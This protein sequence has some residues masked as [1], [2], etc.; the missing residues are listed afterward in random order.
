MHRNVFACVVI[1]LFP[2]L[3]L[4]ACDLIATVNP[5]LVDQATEEIINPTETILYGN[6]SGDLY[7][8]IEDGFTSPIS[9]QWISH[10][11][12]VL[13]LSVDKGFKEK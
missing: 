9:D 12:D 4:S 10:F 6:Y 7:L 2:F 8:S 11:D 1:L 3:S 5:E 13:R